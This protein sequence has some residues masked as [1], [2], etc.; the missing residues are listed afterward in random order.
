M[1]VSEENLV[2]SKRRFNKRNNLE[3][4]S[5]PANGKH[6][7]LKL[8]MQELARR[9]INNVLLESGADFQGACIEAGIVDELR[10]YL[11]PLLLGQSPFGILQLPQLQ[12]MQK[13]ITLKLQNVQRIADDVLLTYHF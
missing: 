10:V 11:A 13:R 12:T 1:I 8:L 5:L 4:I 6:F 7:D 3:I 9:E 2:E